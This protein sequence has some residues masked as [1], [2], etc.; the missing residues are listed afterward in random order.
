MKFSEFRQFQPKV[1][2]NV[3]GFV[4]EDDFLIEQSRDVWSRIFGG[5]WLFEKVAAKEFEDIPASRIMDFALTPSLFSQNRAFMV[6]G[7]EKLTRSR[8]EHLDELQAVPQSSLKII[9]VT[10]NRKAGEAW[11]KAIPVI[12]IEPLKQAEAARWIVER[13]KLNPEV[14]RY[15]VENVGTELCLLDSEI[16]KLQTYVADRAVEVR[17]VD[18]LILRSEQYGPFE[19]GDAVLARDYRRSVKILGAMLEDG[20][21]PLMILGQITRVWRQ[22]LVGKALS[23]K[24]GARDLAMAAG[25]PAFKAADFAAACRNFEWKKVAGG[26]RELL[27]ADRALKGST[28]NP[29]GYLD[30]MLWKLIG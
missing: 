2:P 11:S 23:G 13:Y 7:A 28:P 10:G 29:E 1:N 6:A 12:D 18:V 3:V 25:V 30:V 4:C 17:D 9:L 21:E 15:I 24:R 19:L 22:L 20:V 14:A 5:N 27:K 8:M 26:F 16:R